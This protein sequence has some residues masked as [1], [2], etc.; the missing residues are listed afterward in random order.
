VKCCRLRMIDKLDI[1]VSGL[2]PFTSEFRKAYAELRHDP[3]G[4]LD[5][6][7]YYFRLMLIGFFEGIESER[8]IAWQVADS[9]RPGG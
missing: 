1:R 4:P 9:L 3:K 8:G 5:S 7:Q 6:S 2:A